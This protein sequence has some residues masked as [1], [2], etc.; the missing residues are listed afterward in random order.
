M[1]GR[2]VGAPVDFS[3]GGY[4]FVLRVINPCI[5]RVFGTTY[6]SLTIPVT[7]FT[8]YATTVL[9]ANDASES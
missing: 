6:N 7:F 8:N 5:W 1:V 4:T 3:N 9:N 2:T